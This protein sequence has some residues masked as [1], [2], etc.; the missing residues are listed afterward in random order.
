[1]AGDG[2]IHYLFVNSGEAVANSVLMLGCMNG[3]LGDF[4]IDRYVYR[5]T[6]GRCGDS[7]TVCVF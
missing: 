5:E 3:F 2:A 1:M 4:R 7:V 6:W